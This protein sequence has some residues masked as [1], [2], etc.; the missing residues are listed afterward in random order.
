MILRIDD[1]VK[2]Y[3]PVRAVD[4]LSLEI[5]QGEVL[6]LVGESAAASRPSASACCA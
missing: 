2:H 3:G 5:G 1:L 4:G 6:G